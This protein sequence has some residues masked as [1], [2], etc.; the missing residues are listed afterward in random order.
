MSHAHAP[1]WHRHA[2]VRAVASSGSCAV[3]KPEDGRDRSVSGSDRL[4][5]AQVLRHLLLQAQQL[6][7]LR[8]VVST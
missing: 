1:R 4:D 3:Q 2:A 6:H 5:W 7:L 8:H